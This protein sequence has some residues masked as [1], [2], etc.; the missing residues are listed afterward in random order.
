[1]IKI[2]EGSGNFWTWRLAP[3]DVDDCWCGDAIGANAT[4]E[5]DDDCDVPCA[6]NASQTCGA[7]GNVDV[8]SCDPT[9]PAGPQVPCQ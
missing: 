7:A 3:S 5:P 4:M 9:P 8:F 1:M 6:G 2:Y